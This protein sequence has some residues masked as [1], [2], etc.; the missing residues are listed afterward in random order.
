MAIPK[1][2]GSSSMERLAFYVH[3]HHHSQKKILSSS[4]S[5]YMYICT[6]DCL[7]VCLV[8]FYVWL[9]FSRF[10][11]SFDFLIV[12]TFSKFGSQDLLE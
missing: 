1:I 8:I 9:F 11:T 7:F 6:M 2:V 3:H 10:I 4:S 5:K 12:F